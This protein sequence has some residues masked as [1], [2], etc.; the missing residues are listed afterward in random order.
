M[1]A[2]PVGAGTVG[3]S[4]GKRAAVSAACSPR[5]GLVTD[6]EVAA[7]LERLTAFGE[8]QGTQIRGRVLQRDPDGDAAVGGERPVVLVG[9]PG[10]VAATRLLVERLDVVH[11][12][13][14][15]PQELGRDAGMS[16]MKAKVLTAVLICQMF[17]TWRKALP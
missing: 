17:D 11:P 12:H 14:G 9:V 3:S 10:G 1:V 4:T 13:G 7:D 2:R 15:H 16:S 6:S 5:S 8:G